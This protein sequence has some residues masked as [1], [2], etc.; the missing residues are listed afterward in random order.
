MDEDPIYTYYK[1]HEDDNLAAANI[2]EC[3]RYYNNSALDDCAPLQKSSRIAD[4]LDYHFTT[5]DLPLLNIDVLGKN[6]QGAPKPFGCSSSVAFYTKNINEGGENGISALCTAG[7]SY[8]WGFSFPLLLIV[9]ILNLVFAATMYGLWVDVRRNGDLKT[10]RVYVRAPGGGWNR[11]LN[12]PS[13]LRSSLDISKQ[14]ELQYG[15]DVHD[16]P[17]WKLDS[18]V[19]R[20]NKGIRLQGVA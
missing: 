5:L 8:Q 6:S 20:G 9:S 1:T 18:L 17:S 11:S 13:S 10:I 4:P 19:W 7:S 15:K 14:A 3:S 2:P 12:T 16:W